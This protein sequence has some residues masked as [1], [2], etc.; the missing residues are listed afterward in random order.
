MAIAGSVLLVTGGASGIGLATVEMFAQDG[1]KVI[2]SDIQKEPGEAA[3]ERLRNDGHDVQFVYCDVGDSASVDNLF[4][5]IRSLHGRLDFAFNNAGVE[6]K[7]G[8]IE[9]LEPSEWDR[10]INV[11]LTS[12]FR[13]LQHEIPMMREAGGGVIINCSSIAGLVGTRGGGI[14]CASKHGVIGLTRA[15]ALDVARENIRVNAVCPGAID[16][17]MVERAI[18]ARPEVRTMI[19][20][21]QPLGRMGSAVEIAAAVR[22]LCQPEAALVTGIALPLDGAWTAQ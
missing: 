22:W 21:M 8:P 3:A 16:T 7:M 1:A 12:I 11:N 10:V 15:V 17:A 4:D 6:G 14:Y 20:G 13:F 19:E 18:D 2:L 5:E 9:S